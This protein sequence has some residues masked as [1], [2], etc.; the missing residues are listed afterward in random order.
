[1]GGGRRTHSVSALLLVD[2]FVVFLQ[3]LANVKANSSRFV[4]ANLPVNKF[5]NRLVNI[6][7]C[8]YPGISCNQLGACLHD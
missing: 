3:K 5:K 2:R 1:M 7:P 6:L 8:K 4:S